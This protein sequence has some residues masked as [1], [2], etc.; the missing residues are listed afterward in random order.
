MIHSPGFNFSNQKTNQ[1][2]REKLTR[3]K[4]LNIK[5]SVLPTNITLLMIDDT[6]PAVSLSWWIMQLIR[7]LIP[8]IFHLNRL[9]LSWW[10]FDRY[11]CCKALLAYHNCNWIMFIFLSSLDM[12]LLFIICHLSTVIECCCQR[13]QYRQRILLYLRIF[14]VA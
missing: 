14:D 10:C 13:I 2:N 7:K 1:T 8:C 6:C 4:H 5:V 3:C 9:L 11:I 12:T